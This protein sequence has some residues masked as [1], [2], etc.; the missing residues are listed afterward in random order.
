MPS[1]HLKD[2]KITFGRKC[3]NSKL[4]HH[5]LS[6]FRLCKKTY[7]VILSRRLP[8]TRL[9]R[10]IK[11]FIRERNL[12]RF[13]PYVLWKWC[14]F[15]F[16]GSYFLI[17]H[18]K[19]G[20]NVLWLATKP[21]KLKTFFLKIE[22]ISFECEECGAKFASNSHLKSH[23]DNRHLGIKRW[24]WCSYIYNFLSKNINQICIHIVAKFPCLNILHFRFHCTQCPMKYNRP[25][26]FRCSFL[27]NR[28]NFMT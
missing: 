4:K 10:R 13:V 23:I 18:T 3:S 22:N 21:S 20:A 14:N 12:F 28:T 7:H 11:W 9:S 27:I 17:P 24:D 5:S 1:I 15:V 26:Q 2:C 6:L 8:Q 25:D 19:H 16:H